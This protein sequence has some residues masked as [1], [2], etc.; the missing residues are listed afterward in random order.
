[1]HAPSALFSKDSDFRALQ[2][3]KA[4]SNLLSQQPRCVA[5]M[6]HTLVSAP[7]ADG[8]CH[9]NDQLGLQV[10]VGARIEE[11]PL[12]DWST[13]PFVVTALMPRQSGHPLLI[14]DRILSINGQNV[15]Q[16]SDINLLTGPLGTSVDVVVDRVLCAP[17]PLALSVPRSSVEEH[18]GGKVFGNGDV[19]FQG[20]ITKDG[21]FSSSFKRRW[22][23]LSIHIRLVREKKLGRHI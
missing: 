14:G 4:A 23:Q 21:R 16:I 13:S 22:A 17:Q 12:V 8:S 7:S 10:S 20:W 2:R 3:A 1:M 6:Q 15:T 9:H 11:R 5:F 18:F 19:I